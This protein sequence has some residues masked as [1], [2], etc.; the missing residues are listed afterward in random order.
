MGHSFIYKM[1]KRFASGMCSGAAHFAAKRADGRQA[2]GI[3]FFMLFTSL[4]APKV[5]IENPVGIMSTQYRK[6]DQVIHPYQFGHPVSKATCLWLKGLPKL[7]STLIVE[8]EWHTSSKGR[9]QSMWDYEISK[10]H[11]NRASLR[12]RTFL[13]IAEAM[14]TQWG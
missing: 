12:S 3:N 6:P 5:V 13:G 2:A 11:K 14:A 9:R 4:N 8:P 1:L 7:T 10:D